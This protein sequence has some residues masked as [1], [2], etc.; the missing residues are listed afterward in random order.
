[1]IYFDNSATSY[2][3]PSSVLKHSAYALK[4]NSF[5]SGRG[6]YKQS[7]IAAEKIFDVRQE[8]ADMFSF[9]AQNVVFTKNCTE[10]LNT[11]IRGSVKQGEHVIIS[12]LEHNSVFRV[13]HSLST[14][15][16]FMPDFFSM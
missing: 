13:V 15:R 3:K 5:N 4:Y 16:M 8:I 14:P 11:A 6:G 10:A 7:L 12:S 2:P 1:M 9:P